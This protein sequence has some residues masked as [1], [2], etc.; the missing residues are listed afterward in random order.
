MSPQ[1]RPKGEYRSAKREGSPVSAPD[2]VCIV[3][4]D[5][6]MRKVLA[7]IV[8]S[9]GLAAESFDS[10]EAFLTWRP[11]VRIGCLLVDVELQGM[12]GVALLETLP[13]GQ[14]DFP[15]F[16]ISGAH[17]ARTTDSAKRH[18]AIV[19]DKPFDARSLAQR[20]RAAVR[21]ASA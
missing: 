7:H 13:A 3:D 21:A 15:V 17:D 18:G 6:D 9:A 20:I 5:E 11:D 16:L 10:A 2:I 19:V 4:D 14:R 1:G 8:R 12:S